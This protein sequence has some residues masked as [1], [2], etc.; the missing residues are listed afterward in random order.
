MVGRNAI[1]DQRVQQ[2]LKI[3]NSEIFPRTD[4]DSE[5]FQN[6]SA[7]LKISLFF[8]K[9]KKHFTFVDWLALTLFLL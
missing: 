7:A 5:R 2:K 1:S 4:R 8:C 6:F 9:T 3:E